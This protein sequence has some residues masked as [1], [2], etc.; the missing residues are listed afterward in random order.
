MD[1]YMVSNN[2]KPVN[3]FDVGA[4]GTVDHTIGPRYHA[5]QYF[6][7]ATALAGHT[8]VLS[9]FLAQIVI[10]LNG[11]PQ[12]V[13]LATE[14]DAIQGFWNESGTTQFSAQIYNYAGGA[15]NYVNG[16]PQA[17]QA[18][19]LTCCFFTTWFT[20]PWRK[21]WAGAEMFS[22]P[23]AF[24]NGAVVKSFQ[25]QLIGGP[26]TNLAAGSHI[27][28]VH[29]PIVDKGLGAVDA[30][31]NPVLLINKWSRNPT[32]YGGAGNVQI[33]GLQKK[34]AYQEIR[35]FC[36][37]GDDITNVQ[38]TL[39]GDVKRQVTKG[40]NDAYCLGRGANFN[41]FSVDRF[42]LIF[43]ITDKP[44][45][46]LQ[47]SPGGTPVTGDFNVT[48]TLNNA[49][50]ANKIINVLSCRYGPPD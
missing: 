41:S 19:A 48:V 26:A 37:A 46:A 49:A 10:L 34:D 42:D 29:L 6:L 5:N 1:T 16:L 36:Q 50:A 28:C 3:G 32:P 30:N 11:N 20:E 12:R 35:F 14:L 18:G 43:D 40:Q 24:T 17:A 8:L 47:L 4:Q 39:S 38:V 45:D 31:G 33:L 25:T 23:T 44:S 27:T 7:T 21:T 9:D 2:G 13:H 22:W 15:I